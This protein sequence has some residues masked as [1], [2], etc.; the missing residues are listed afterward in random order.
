MNRHNE[1]VWRTLGPET[2]AELESMRVDRQ[3]KGD[4]VH[5]FC[6]LHSR[7]GVVGPW[8]I[9]EI[10]DETGGHRSNSLNAEKFRWLLKNFNSMIWQQD[11]APPHTS[12]ETMRFFIDELGGESR[13]ISSRGRAELPPGGL[14]WPPHSPDLTP[15][16]FWF[17]SIFKNV[18]GQ[19]NPRTTGT[20]LKVLLRLAIRSMDTDEVAKAIR[21]IPTRLRC[22][23]HT[24]GMHIEGRVLRRFKKEEST[25]AVQDMC[26]LCG[27]K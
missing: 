11:G 17:W 20:R 22:V 4:E 7:L 27:Q 10:P 14:E 1:V 2:G 3:K 18:V 8:F 12:R 23:V 6:F 16:D 24:N 25:M 26:Y 19:Q 13:I 21:S 15:L 9:N 5:V